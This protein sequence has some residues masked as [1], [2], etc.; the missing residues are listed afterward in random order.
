MTNRYSPEMGGQ[1]D[2]FSGLSSEEKAIMLRA[3][4]QQMAGRSGLGVGAG[5]SFEPPSSEQVDHGMQRSSNLKSAP[6]DAHV[7]S[8]S[9]SVSSDRLSDPRGAKKPVGKK[10]S[11]QP[12]EP[13]YGQMLERIRALSEPT[14]E[15]SRQPKDRSTA[16]G[17]TTRLPK[18]RA[19]LETARKHPR[20]ALVALGA[21]TGLAIGM[22]VFG[23]KSQDNELAA[24]GDG[25]AVIRVVGEGY[26]DLMVAHKD[27]GQPAVRVPGQKLNLQGNLD[28]ETKAVLVVPPE[29]QPEFAVITEENGKQIVNINPEA[30]FVDFSMPQPQYCAPG[31]CEDNKNTYYSDFLKRPAGE[32]AYV[33]EGPMFNEAT[34]QAVTNQITLDPVAVTEAEQ[35]KIAVKLSPEND[36]YQLNANLG[37]ISATL[38]TPACQNAFKEV[39][40]DLRDNIVKAYQKLGE[41]TGVTYEVI[42]PADKQFPSDLGTALAF[43]DSPE[44]FVQPNIKSSSCDITVSPQLTGSF[45]RT[46]TGKS[47]K[48]KGE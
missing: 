48:G 7:P 15:P 37:L 39:Q 11:P 16:P 22:G 46:V 41:E 32:K 25:G 38:G 23:A 13:T 28:I 17:S 5:P 2:R 10:R 29:K 44:A 31:K 33:I 21:I 45:V 3:V 4:K 40:A 26:L 27:A 24:S 6:S 9:N 34:Q 20:R 8:R 14:T 30:A 42:I 43:K 47:L 35:K 1:G 19:L 18:G 36:T 12:S